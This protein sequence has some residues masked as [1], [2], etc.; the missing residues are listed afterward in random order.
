MIRR[1]K[2]CLNGRRRADDHPAG[3]IT[4]GRLAGAA[5]AAA[6]TA[7]LVRRALSI[8]EISAS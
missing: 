1:I 4:P 6:S 5:A 7:G 3:P 2:A 8:R